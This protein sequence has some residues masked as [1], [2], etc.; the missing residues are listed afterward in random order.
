MATAMSIGFLFMG[1]GRVTFGTSNQ[2]IASLVA[3]LFP[4]FPVTPLDDQGHLQ[5][6]RHLWVLAVQRRCLVTRDESSGQAI[7]SSVSIQFKSGF[8][9]I[10]RTPCLLPEFDQIKSL[11]VSQ[12]GWFSVHLDL[13]RPLE[14]WRVI[15]DQEIFMKAHSSMDLETSETKVKRKWDSILNNHSLN[16]SL[17]P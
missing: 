5:A 6:F 15:E 13:S 12:P 16:L 3:S 17:L 2:C 14:S 9:S 8:D 1:G 10:Q 4:R 11:H 7:R